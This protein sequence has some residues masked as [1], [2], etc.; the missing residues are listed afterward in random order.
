MPNIHSV[1]MLNSRCQMPAVQKHVGEQLPHVEAVHRTP[2]TERQRANSD[3][4]LQRA[5]AQVVSRK[6]AVLTISSHFTPGGK[7]PIEA[8]LL[9]GYLRY[10]S[11]RDL[12]AG[13]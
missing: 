3:I 11:W 10:S 4:G 7:Y 6:I 8:D 9:D 13:L 12:G 5:A 1:S 2:C